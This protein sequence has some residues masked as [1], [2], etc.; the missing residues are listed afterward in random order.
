MYLD[1]QY[2]RQRCWCGKVPKSFTTSE[3]PVTYSDQ[4]VNREL[5]EVAPI[6]DSCKFSRCEPNIEPPKRL[7]LLKMT[8]FFES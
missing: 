3:V 4:E 2:G 7:D 1:A 6:T 8:I 5:T